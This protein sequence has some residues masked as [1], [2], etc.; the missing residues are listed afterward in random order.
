[1]IKVFFTISAIRYLLK[2]P[3]SNLNCLTMNYPSE[4]LRF[5]CGSMAIIWHVNIIYCCLCVKRQVCHFLNDGWVINFKHFFLKLENQPHQN[6][7][8]L[9]EK[10]FL[11]FGLK[12]PKVWISPTVLEV[13]KSSERLRDA[14]KGTGTKSKCQKVNANFLVDC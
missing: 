11:G 12:Q 4:A 2:A 8:F 14:L 7:Y 10:D 1:M 3:V 9:I 13:L 6:K 5:V